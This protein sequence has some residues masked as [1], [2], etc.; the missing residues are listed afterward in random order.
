MS[1]AAPSDR[2]LYARNQHLQPG[3][4]RHGVDPV[5]RFPSRKRDPAGVSRHSLRTRRYLRAADKYGWTLV[6]PVSANPDPSGIVTDDAFEQI[7]GMILEAADTGAVARARS[8][9]WWRSH[10]RLAL[11]WETDATGEIEFLAPRGPSQ[12]A[13]AGSGSDSNR[14]RTLG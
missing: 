8:G 6:H 4:N 5:P 3:Q 14:W 13:P 9:A 11:L 1:R 7:A 12:A 2:P 10:S